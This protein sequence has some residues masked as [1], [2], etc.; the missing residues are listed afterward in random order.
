MSTKSVIQSLPPTHL[1]RRPVAS[2]AV[3]VAVI[4]PSYG[5]ERVSYMIPSSHHHYIKLHRL[6]LHK[7]ERHSTFF[8]QT[9]V[10][11]GPKVDLVHT[12]NHIPV[13]RPFVVTAEME[14]PRYLGRARSWQNRIGFRLL[15]SDRC[16]GIWPLSDAAR[17]YI[18]RH[19]DDA[20]Y[21]YL[22][23]KMAVFRGAVPS[24]TNEHEGEGRTGSGPLRLLFVGG[25]GLRKGLR[26][27]LEAARR[28]RQWGIEVELT[29]VGQPS[30]ETYLVPGIIFPTVDLGSMLVE[31]SWIRY[32]PSLPNLEVRR[33]MCSHDLFV[34]PT[35]DE[36]LGWVIVEAAMSGLPSVTTNVFAIPE[37]VLNGVSGWT[38][39]LPLDEDRR[40]AYAGDANARDAWMAAQTEIAERLTNILGAVA[41]DRALIVRFGKS[42]RQHIASRYAIDVARPRLERLYAT[43]IADGIAPLD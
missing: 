19:F 33:Q 16:R 21:A 3:T 11:V 20:G 43:A 27:T 14:L 12:F 25:D 34:L 4:T 10:I 22:S 41:V 18:A 36:S 39:D 38:I 32:H 28:L 30:A 9:P 26:P 37:L 42:A 24:T 31:E 6:P 40:W 15:A 29:V 5:M 17:A 7:W 13:N 23:D 1:F 2:Q 8:E 35:M